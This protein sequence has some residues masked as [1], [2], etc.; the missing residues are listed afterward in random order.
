MLNSHRA[1]LPPHADALA[2][3]MPALALATFIPTCLGFV[4]T[5]WAFGFGYALSTFAAGALALLVPT[6]AARGAGA[7]P[8]PRAAALQALGATAHGLRLAHYLFKR[9]RG[10]AMPDDYK[11]RIA[12]IDGGDATLLGRL[13]RLPLVASCAGMYALIASP[14][15]FASAHPSAGD[16]S[17]GGG[18]GAASAMQWAGVALQWTGLLTAAVADWQKHAHKR[19][20]PDR[21]CDTGLY[22]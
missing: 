12:A 8:L 14:L 13:K 15:V 18:G 4:R 16:A 1:L 22:R 5:H 9:E 10:A 6:A 20:H 19:K 2:L 11:A 21:W 3:P 7:P 17:S